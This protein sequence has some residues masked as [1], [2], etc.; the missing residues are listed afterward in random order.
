MIGGRSKRAIAGLPVSMGTLR[1]ICAALVLV[2][3]IIVMLPASGCAISLPTAGTPAVKVPVLSSDGEFQSIGKV[4]GTVPEQYVSTYTISLNRPRNLIPYTR[5]FAFDPR[6]VNAISFYTITDNAALLNRFLR[7]P[8][9]WSNYPFADRIKYMQ[10]TFTL[11]R[12][13][14]ISPLVDTYLIV[15][16]GVGGDAFINSILNG[17]KFANIG[18][19]STSYDITVSYATYARDARTSDGY[20]NIF[21]I[22]RTQGERGFYIDE[23]QR[24]YLQPR[25]SNWTATR[26]LDVGVL[27]I[28]GDTTPLYPATLS[29]VRLIYLKEAP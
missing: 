27:R 13:E 22:N 18:Y 26:A 6:I 8:S 20:A 23:S 1:P 15:Y 24:E 12:A 9:N 4:Q 17:G 16:K 14:V 10:Y 28:R 25:L 2:I 29:K 7:N 19:S 3:C 5:R 21:I 11:D